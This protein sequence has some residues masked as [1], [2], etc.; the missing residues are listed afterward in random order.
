MPLVEAKETH[1]ERCKHFNRDGSHL[2]LQAGQIPRQVTQILKTNTQNPRRG[3]SHL[4]QD[5]HFL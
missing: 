5:I 2:L 1:K 4:E 3:R